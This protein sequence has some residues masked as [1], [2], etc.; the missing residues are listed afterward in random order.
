[1]YDPSR[2]AERKGLYMKKLNS[3]VDLDFQSPGV[4]GWSGAPPA[5][6]AAV[7][8]GVVLCS[9]VYTGMFQN[10]TQAGTKIY[11]RI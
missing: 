6:E 11:T 2:V 8:H 7:D 9:L 1:M 10:R 4:R 5:A 3:S